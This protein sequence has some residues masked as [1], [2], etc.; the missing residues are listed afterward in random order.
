MRFDFIG[1]IQETLKPM[2][3]IL[4][5]GSSGFIARHLIP[6]FQ[7]IGY[8][9]RGL[10]LLASTLPQGDDYTHLQGDVRNFS[11]VRDSMNGV[12]SIVHLAAA[13]KDFGVPDDEYYSVNVAGTKNLLDVATDLGIKDFVFYSSVAVYGDQAPEA[14]ETTRTNPINHYGKSKLEAEQLIKDW[15]DETQDRRAIVIRPAVVI[16]PHNTANMYKLI[17]AID[18][19]FYIQIGDGE[20]KKSI[21]GVSN[22]VEA[23]LYLWSSATEKYTLVNYVDKPDL[24]S[25]KISEVIAGTL[26][27]PIRKS[28][29]SLPVLLTLAKPMDMIGK[30]TGMDIPITTARIKKYLSTTLFSADKIREL[31]FV[32]T[33]DTEDAVK[34][35]VEWYL[36]QPN[37]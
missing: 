32:P 5:T 24:S 8:Q 12:Q 7:T 27:R 15:A 36:Q 28:P 13:H 29:L 33:R 37:D 22:L 4:V 9:V 19:R 16:G 21:A 20:N 35:M 18:R 26:G 3:S 14:A 25:K 10:D 11:N 34:D 2:N 23:T 30:M 17:K 1:L 6:N 31:G